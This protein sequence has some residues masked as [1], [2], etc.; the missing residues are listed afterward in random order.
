MVIGGPTAS[1]KSAIALALAEN[2]QAKGQRPVVLNADALQVY[3]D[4]SVLTAR[5]DAADEARAPHRLYGVIDGAT[6]GTVALW[7]GM[8]QEEIAAILQTGGWP[9]VV[10]GSGMY[11]HSLMNGLA[12][13]PEIEAELRAFTINRHGEL[14]GAR[15]RAELATLDPGAAARLHDGDTQRLIRAYE[16]VK[17][18]GRT[19]EDWQ[20]DKDIAPPAHW[21][22]KTFV[23][24]PT[25][26]VL[27]SHC[28]LRFDLMLQR[29]AAEEVRHLLA[30][31]L[32]L[33]LPVMK[34]VGV[35]ELAAVFKGEAT[36][37]EA[38]VKAQQATRNYAKR[39]LTWF[40]H[41]LPAAMRLEHDRPGEEKENCDLAAKIYA[42]I[43]K[44]D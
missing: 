40:R 10:G 24:S 31:Q 35:P 13:V 1:G 19:L 25:R 14:G 5:P 43:C 30:R 9:I 21:R 20:Q 12:I 7:L 23:V 39:Q 44:V 26:P 22:F 15:F 18:T 38:R 27:Y 2:L 16:V 37:T 36:I 42:I 11:L 32:D 17:A 3:R 41:Q 28:D 6:R 4:L 8:I 34:A 33:T 29:G